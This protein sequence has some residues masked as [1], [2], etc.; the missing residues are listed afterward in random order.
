MDYNLFTGDF[1]QASFIKIMHT[2]IIFYN[3]IFVC[4]VFLKM[5]FEGV[6]ARNLLTGLMKLLLWRGNISGMAPLW[7]FCMGVG[8]LAKQN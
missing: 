5:L 6:A 3:I 1:L 2:D 4:I 7:S 8:A